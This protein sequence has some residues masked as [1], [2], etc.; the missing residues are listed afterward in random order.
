MNPRTT[1][2]LVIGAGGMA[3]AAIYAMLQLGLKTILIHN[4]TVA[5][6]ERLVEHFGRVVD[7][8]DLFRGTIL[9]VVRREDEWPA[10][11]RYPTIVVSCVPTHS[12]V[13]GPAADFTLP[14]GWM[15]SPT[16][17]VVLEVR[18]QCIPSETVS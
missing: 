18:P 7:Q 1:T 17:G 10:G 2:G 14:E 3:R 4:R 12:T 16:G 8:S 11:Y 9:R 5:N 13:N 15:K 6:A